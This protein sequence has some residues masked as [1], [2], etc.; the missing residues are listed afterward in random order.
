MK[1]LLVKAL[2]STTDL[3]CR[4]FILNTRNPH[5]GQAFLNLHYGEDDPEKQSLD[6][7]VPEGEGPFPVLIYTHGGGWLSGNKKN[8][9]RICRDFAHH[10]YLVFNINYRLT[11]KDPFPVPLQDVARATRWISEHAPAY[12]GD[13]SRIF[14]GGESAGA[15]L[16]SLYA[17]SLTDPDLRAELLIPWT[18]PAD[19]VKG[20]LLFYGAFDL[21]L[22]GESNFPFARVMC[23]S[24]LGKRPHPPSLDRL[25]S[26]IHHIHKGLPPLFVCAC[27]NDPLHPQS[28]A[29]VSACRKMGLDIEW[30]FLEKKSYPEANH[31]FL[32]YYFEPCAKLAMEK[33][34]DFMARLAKQS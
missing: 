1:A 7:F 19:Q 21:L 25:V 2:Y 9:R 33:S 31:S 16:I 18:I 11:P 22:T 12:G 10:G 30:L 24:F 29:F 20:L 3:L 27:E 15:H 28:I 26:P 34:L 17:E 4:T 14:L 32:A 13:L 6:L 5:V 23:E 8:Y